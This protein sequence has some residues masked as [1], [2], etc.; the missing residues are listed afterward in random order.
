MNDHVFEV[1]YFDNMLGADRVRVIDSPEQ[2]GTFVAMRCMMPNLYTNFRVNPI[3][4]ER[5]D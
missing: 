1:K 2:V 3:R 5:E 4:L